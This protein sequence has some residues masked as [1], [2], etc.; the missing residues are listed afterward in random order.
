MVDLDEVRRWRDDDPDPVTR[1]ELDDLLA[2]GDEAELADRFAHRLEFGTAGL[3]AAMGAGP[4]RM[5]VATVRYAAAGL[6]RHL[7]AR[8][9]Q[10]SVVIGY[11]ARHR[12]A[13]FARESAVVL[14]AAGIGASLLPRPLPTPILA[15]A[16]RH[17]GASA[18]VMVTASHNPAGDNG[19]K[20]YGAD[21]AQ[22]APPVDAQIASA[23][24]NIRTLAD[25]STGLDHARFSELGDDVVEAYLDAAAGVLPPGPRAVTATYTPLHGVAGATFA[26]LARRAG[27]D[28]VHGVAEQAEPDPDFPTVA[29]PNPEEPGALDLAVAD[30]VAR[31]AHV[32]VANDP[33]G[34]GSCRRLTGDELGC[35]LADHLLRAHAGDDPTGLLLATTVVSSRLLG[36]L[37]AEA[38]VRYFETFTGFKWLMRPALA[39]PE[40]RPLLAYEEALGY[41]VG[42]LVRDK[43]GLTA[44]I[45]L[46]AVAAEAVA[47]GPSL[48]DRLDDLARRHG[49]HATGQ[50]AVRDEAPGGLERIRSAVAAVRKTPP[51][52][53][54]GRAV[55]SVR[56]LLQ[57]RPATD[58]LVLE[59]DGDARVVVRPSGTEPK[60]KAYLEVVVPVAGD[61]AVARADADRALAEL[62]T[63]VRTLLERP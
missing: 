43:D 11:D 57:A 8:E 58:A 2:R 39:H 49:V 6:A 28:G 47:G 4:N 55:R 7:R 22:I 59:L 20:V 36:K 63:A 35:L 31:G 32:V 18:G 15:F 12:S 19:Y 44:G 26:E 56:D 46:L 10:P 37:A 61:V 29:F 23:I 9:S 1:A 30:A 17:L 51:T 45:T 42:D 54:A 38:G 34:A 33:D 5:N 62:A 25:V 14:A 40:L 50:V 3:R 52:E 53:L 41:A 21:G 48:Q 13:D 16:V 60:L 24:A 27:F